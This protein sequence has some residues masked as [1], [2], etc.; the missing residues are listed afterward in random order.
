MHGRPFF[1]REFEHRS[2]RIV[3]LCRFAL[4]TVFFTALWI[5]PDQPVR[6]STTGYVMLFGYMLLS[7]LVLMIAWRNWWWDQRLAWP[8]HL[9]DVALFLAAVYFTETNNDGFTSPFLAFFAYLMLSSTIRWDWRVTA[10]TAVLV[11]GQSNRPARPT[12]AFRHCSMR[13]VM[14]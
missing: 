12:S 2:G 3:A 11:A 13:S 7:S 10:Q 14:R 5:A 9:V 8:M 4:A 1:A 6:S